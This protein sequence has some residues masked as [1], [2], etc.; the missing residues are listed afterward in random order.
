VFIS[1]STIFTDIHMDVDGSQTRRRR[2]VV[3]EKPDTVVD[4]S[5]YLK[6]VYLQNTEHECG[7]G[8][9]LP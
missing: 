9:G 2:R 4:F 6:T 7:G 8:S 5:R 3:G 1:N